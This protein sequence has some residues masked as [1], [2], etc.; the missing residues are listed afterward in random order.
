MTIRAR[1]RLAV[2]R[3]MLPD[4]HF[5][6]VINTA[7][8]AAAM[9]VIPRYRVQRAV[10]VCILIFLPTSRKKNLTIERL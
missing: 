4:Y 1:A 9:L 7:A 6:S 10:C 3:L 8:T 5:N 2:T